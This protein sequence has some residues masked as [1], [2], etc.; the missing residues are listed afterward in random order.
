M[1]MN[2]LSLFDGIACARIALERLDIRI[3]N[4][5]ASEIDKYAIKVA[6][7][8]YG[9][10]QHVGDVK[11]LHGWDFP[12]INLLIAGSPCQGFSVA[13]RMLNF[14]DPRSKL[15][16]EFARLKEEVR[17]DYFL[18]ENVK[19]K[20]EYQNIISDILGVEPIKIN[21]ALVSA[22]NRERLYWTNIPNV[23][24]PADRGILLKD[25][26]EEGEVD[27]DKSYCI[28][29]NYYKGG[30]LNNY[31][32]KKRRQIVFRQSE[33]RLMV[34]VGTAN[35]IKG[36]DYNK[37]IYSQEGKSPALNAKGGGNIEP[38][39]ALDMEHWRKLTCE[40]CETLQTVDRGYTDV[41]ISKT[42]RYKCLGNAFTVDVIAHILSFIP[43]RMEWSE[44]R[45][46][47]I[48]E[49]D[50]AGLHPVEK[51]EFLYN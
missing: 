30:S 50:L 18:L 48:T 41:G 42:Q 29:A 1:E 6:Q 34:R 44:P 10:I 51:R 45:F 14:D 36:H 27:R 31:L 46:S 26:I 32:E 22:Q 43:E 11:D 12:H 8:N 39:I 4:Y 28:D 15:F 5:F 7:S 20:K 25:I 9:E 16:F 24:Q 38:K 47:Q 17:P 23:A 19:M 49:F 33:K 3:D 37:R 35:D 2:V 21:S 13:G 40:E